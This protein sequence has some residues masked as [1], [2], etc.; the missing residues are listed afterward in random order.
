MDAKEGLEHHRVLR[1]R[2]RHRV[3]E[4][5]LG[6][7]VEHRRDVPE[8]HI[9]VHEDGRHGRELSEAD[10]QVGG[11]RGLADASLG[12]G[13]RDHSATETGRSSVQGRIRD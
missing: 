3:G 7:E 2:T 4:R 6:G 11:D 10:R 12:R 9:Q 13:H 8:L 1:R 5:V